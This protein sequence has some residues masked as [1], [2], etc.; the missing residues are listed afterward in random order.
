M[1]PLSRRHPQEARSHAPLR[2]PTG[3]SGAATCPCRSTRRTRELRASGRCANRS[4]RLSIGQV[5]IALRRNCSARRRETLF[6]QLPVAFT[7]EKA[8]HA[9]PEPCMKHPRRVVCAIVA[10]QHVAAVSAV[11]LSAACAITD[12][13]ARL[14]RA[15][16]QRPKRRRHP[17]PKPTTPDPRPSTSRACFTKR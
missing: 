13:S 7:A 14:L 11:A 8:H 5:A 4:C 9:R 6:R 16:M 15:T 10:T 3:S 17:P 1:L 12:Y 2:G